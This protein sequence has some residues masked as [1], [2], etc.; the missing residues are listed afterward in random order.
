MGS[1]ADWGRVLTGAGYF[2]AIMF[3]VW[4]GV[5]YRRAD[6]SPNP[7]LRVFIASVFAGFA[8]GFSSTFHSRIWH[9]PLSIVSVA[10]VV[11]YLI[12]VFIFRRQVAANWRGG[13]KDLAVTAKAIASWVR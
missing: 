13:W 5:N 10:I 12:F 7:T 9:W 6:D 2:A 8:S 4:W 11:L 1:L 3:V